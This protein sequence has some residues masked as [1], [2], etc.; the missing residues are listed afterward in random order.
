MTQNAR[1]WAATSIRRSIAT[2]PRAG[3][4]FR[5]HIQTHTDTFTRGPMTAAQY[6]SSL[7]PNP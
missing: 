2:G 4:E 3:L 5:K 6:L 1:R 7:G